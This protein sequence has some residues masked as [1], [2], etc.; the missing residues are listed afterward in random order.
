[1]NQ[2]CDRGNSLYQKLWTHLDNREKCNLK[3]TKFIFI[4]HEAS[5]VKLSVLGFEQR[6]KAVTRI[7]GTFCR[8]IVSFHQKL[9]E[10]NEKRVRSCRCGSSLRNSSF[11]QR[12]SWIFDCHHCRECRTENVW[13]SDGYNVLHHPLQLDRNSQ[14]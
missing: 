3:S 7:F 2:G 12:A 9:D 6:W 5:K 4:L 1:M 10:T 14:L 11:V 13:A 8:K